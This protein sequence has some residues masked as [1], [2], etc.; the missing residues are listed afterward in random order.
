MI[1]YIMGLDLY[2]VLNNSYKDGNTQSKAFNKQGYDYDAKL[3]NGNEQI[4][5]NPKEKKLLMSIAGTHNLSDIATDAWLTV[6]K[7]KDTT[8]FKEGESVLQRAKQKY[9]IDSATITGH[10]LGGS[11]AQYIGSKQ[12]KVISFNKGSTIGAPIRSNETAYRTNGDVVSALNANSTRMQ[13]F[14][15]NYKSG[16]ILIDSYLAHNLDNIKNQKIKI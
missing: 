11:V 12:D 4:Y 6:G 16:N 8:R 7:L 15:P 10:S 13:T 1:L 2:D 5:F 9:N 14:N 3:S